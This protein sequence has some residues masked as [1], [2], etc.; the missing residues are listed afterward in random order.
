MEPTIN[1]KSGVRKFSVSKILNSGKQQATESDT[2]TMTAKSPSSIV[3][4]PTGG[5]SNVY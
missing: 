2:F 1:S 5:S 3:N 4:R